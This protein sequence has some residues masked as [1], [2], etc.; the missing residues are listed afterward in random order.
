LFEN[1]EAIIFDMDGTLLDSGRLHEFAWTQT[2]V[3]FGIPVDRP[4]M[5][6]L[7]GVPTH[8]TFELLLENFNL[9]AAES[10]EIMTRYKDM[11]VGDKA[12]DFI[13]PTAL[14][15]VAV[16][17]HGKLPMCIGTG[18]ASEEA[19]T[20]LRYCEV[21][22][23]FDHVVGADQ[24]SNPKPSPD[25]FLLCAQLMGVKPQACVVFEDSPLGLEA[26]SAAGMT[27]I[28]VLEKFQIENDYFLG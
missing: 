10:I 28:D 24:V 5:R 12:K 27:G 4:L 19:R 1:F 9:V 16:Q 15:D 26:A 21:D 7:C 8:Q 17:S 14:V 18:A 3:K 13:K 25:T 23:L 6:S 22:H 11:L 2:L 20:F